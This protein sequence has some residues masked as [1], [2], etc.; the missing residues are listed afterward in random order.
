MRK[1]IA[2]CVLGIGIAQAPILSYAGNAPVEKGPALY[3]EDGHRLGTIYT[4]GDDGSAKLILDG[5]MVTIP[6]ST[7]S[8]VGGKLTTTLTKEQVHDLRLQ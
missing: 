2:L 3:S 6:A 8:D 1:L 4:V 7:L 5:K